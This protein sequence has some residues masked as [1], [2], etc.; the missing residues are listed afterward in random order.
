[1]SKLMDSVGVSKLWEKVKAYVKLK[2]PTKVSQLTNDSGFVRGEDGKGLS[3]NDFTT[4]EKEKLA[5]IAEGANNYTLPTAGKELGGVKTTSTVTSA[6]GYT[7]APIIGGVPYFKNTTYSDAT[8]TAHGLLSTADKKKLDAFD[9]A[10]AYATKEDVAKQITEA[11]HLKR[12]KVT[13]LPAPSEAE[14]NI[15]HMVKKETPSGNNVYDEWMLMDGAME[16]MGD[17][18]ADIETLTADEIEALLSMDD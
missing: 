4:A 1:M 16:R 5:G 11:D 3:T 10:S 18:Q 7:A 6:S 8:Q 2:M 13:A 17:T 12:R 9:E 14:E 15:I